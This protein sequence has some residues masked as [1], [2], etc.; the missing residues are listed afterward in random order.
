LAVAPI[1]VDIHTQTVCVD[2]KQGGT[3]RNH[4]SERLVVSCVQPTNQP[5]CTQQNKKS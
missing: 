2:V 3:N 5:D 1:D 4:C